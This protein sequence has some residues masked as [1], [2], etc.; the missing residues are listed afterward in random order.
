MLDIRPL[1]VDSVL[2]GQGNETRVWVLT[3][4]I[5]AAQPNP[6]RQGLITQNAYL[7][8]FHC[9][10]FSPLAGSKTREGQFSLT[11]DAILASFLRRDGL[12]IVLLAI[13]LEDV[14][15]VFKSDEKGNI[16]AFARN[17]CRDSR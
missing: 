4:P 14:L 15:T 8:F 10:H 11:E 12:H 9:S 5:E 2:A 17:Y 13:S 1:R 6:R 3:A 16:V 7:L